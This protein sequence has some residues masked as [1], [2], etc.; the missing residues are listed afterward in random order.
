MDIKRVRSRGA[1]PTGASL[2]EVRK[3]REH[4]VVSIEADDCAPSQLDGRYPTATIAEQAGIE[5][6][7]LQ[8]E[9]EVKLLYVVASDA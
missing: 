8:Y 5:A 3:D 1:V 4:Y 2:I 7:R 9:D 6:V